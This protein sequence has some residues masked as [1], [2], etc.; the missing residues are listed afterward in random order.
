MAISF[1]GQLR[2]AYMFSLR[3]GES[4]KLQNGYN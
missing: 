4:V 1:V 3:K 2:A